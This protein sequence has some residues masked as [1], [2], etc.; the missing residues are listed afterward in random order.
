MT[1]RFRRFATAGLLGFLAVIPL[2]CGKYTGEVSGKVIFKGKPLPGG[3]VTF[4]HPDGR[5]GQAQIQED[6]SYTV[7][8]APG[9]DVKVTVV[10]MKPLP[11]LPPMFAPKGLGGAAKAETVYPAGKYVKIPEK[12]GDKEKSGLTL[13]V[14]RGNQPFD[15]TLTE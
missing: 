5:I 9:G 2:G 11:G 14:K 4:I 10:T 3:I 15:I 12:W 13:T 1:A 8:D 7:S 6:G